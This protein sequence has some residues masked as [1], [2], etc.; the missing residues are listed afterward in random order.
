MTHTGFLSHG[1]PIPSREYSKREKFTADISKLL[2]FLVNKG[3]GVTLGEGFRTKEQQK[4]YYES[5]ASRVMHSQHQ[6]RLAVDL[7]LWDAEDGG[8][9]VDEATWKEAGEY[10][11][12][13][14]SDNRWG[15]DF[16]GFYDPYH[17]ERVG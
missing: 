15:G 8:S 1:A 17:F 7:H 14:D 4:I 10:F 12:D 16:K 11:K 6:K 3:I 13:L 2:V 9:Y 5:G